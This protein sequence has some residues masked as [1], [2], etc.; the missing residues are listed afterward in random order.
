MRASAC[1]H[2]CVVHATYHRVDLDL[3]LDLDLALALDAARARRDVWLRRRSGQGGHGDS[4]H[5]DRRRRRA[6]ACSDSDSQAPPSSWQRQGYWPTAYLRHEAPSR[7]RTAGLWAPE[8]GVG[9]FGP[10][11][12]RPGAPPRQAPLQGAC[13][14]EPACHLP[15]RCA[16]A[17][18]SPSTW[19]SRGSSLVPPSPRVALRSSQSVSQSGSEAVGQ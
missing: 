16:T 9:R 12:V 4:E 7:W 2:T 1:V 6:P 15:C 14:T 5:S 3:D 8:Q 13:V 17:G 10:R 19:S 18:Q 11:G